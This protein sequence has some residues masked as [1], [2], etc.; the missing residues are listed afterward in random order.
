M[1]SLLQS[2]RVQSSLSEPVLEY[3]PEF[4]PGLQHD[5]SEFTMSLLGQVK[6]CLLQSASV[7]VFMLV[8]HTDHMCVATIWR[9]NDRDDDLWP[10]L[11]EFVENRAIPKSRHSFCEK[12]RPNCGDYRR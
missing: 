11:D 6:S 1:Q 7:R 8:C 9:G 4:T 5:A 3:L 12:I 2:L 10:V